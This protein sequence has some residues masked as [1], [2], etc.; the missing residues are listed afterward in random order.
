[1]FDADG[2]Q[3]L[4]FVKQPNPRFDLF[5]VAKIRSLSKKQR[6]IRRNKFENKFEN[7]SF[8]DQL[9]EKQKR[10]EEKKRQDKIND[11]IQ[12]IKALQ[13]VGAEGTQSVLERKKRELNDIL[14][15]NK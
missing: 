12:D 14:K 8:T 9:F 15:G 2:L 7:E 10:D 5:T 6:R 13:I 11:L 3:P 4:N 1:M